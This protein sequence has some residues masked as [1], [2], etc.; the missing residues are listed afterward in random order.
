[1]DPTPDCERATVA[2]VLTHDDL[3]SVFLDIRLDLERM[4]RGR[5]RDPQLAADLTQ[6]IFLRL[7]RITAPLPDRHEARLYLFRMARNLALDHQRV[8][9]RRREILEGA[10]TLF[11]GVAASPED[12]TLAKDQ[13]RVVESALDELP[14]LC[15][16]VLYMSRLLGMSHGE[17]AEEL[18]VSKSLVEK[19]VVR[20]MLHCRAKLGASS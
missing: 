1:M 13:L 20:A 11:E 12:E 7:R 16:D 2:D 15:R 6:D 4:L 8:D 19:Y 10:L 14:K 18:N 9:G 5:V 17:I 3:R